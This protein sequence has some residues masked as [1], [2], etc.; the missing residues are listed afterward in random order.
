MV[1]VRDWRVF[2]GVG[3]VLGEVGEKLVYRRCEAFL[4][5]VRGDVIA[6]VVGFLKLRFRDIVGERVL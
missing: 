2:L 5:Y 6:F 1:R 4:E 3:I